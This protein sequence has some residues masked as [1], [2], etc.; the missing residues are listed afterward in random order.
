MIDNL[1]QIETIN[2]ERNYKEE[3]NEKF[4]V[5]IVLNE[6]KNSAEGLN[7]RFELTGE[8]ICQLKDRLIG[9][10]QYEEQEKKSEEAP[11]ALLSGWT[12]T[13]C[14]ELAG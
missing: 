4:W 8:R 3:L 5:W 6:M 10:M 1:Y 7:Y 2:K 13:Q 11:L 12:S 14:Q 9:I